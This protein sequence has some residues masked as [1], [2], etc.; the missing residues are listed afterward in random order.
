MGPTRAVT[1]R[2]R[3]TFWRQCSRR[4]SSVLSELWHQIRSECIYIAG[5]ILHLSRVCNVI[6]LWDLLHAGTSTGCVT[7]VFR[8]AG[9]E[10]A[11]S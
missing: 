2:L 1:V 8:Q 10:K 5:L 3:R 7:R 9:I 11:G 6:H 4:H